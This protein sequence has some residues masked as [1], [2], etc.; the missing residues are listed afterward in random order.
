MAREPRARED[1]LMEDS[2]VGAP[3]RIG[4]FI[5][6]CGNN[7][8]GF[9]DVPQVTEYA[10]TLPHVVWAQD[11][12]YTCSD[13][14]RAEIV[15][16]IAEH[17]L[18]RVVVASCTPRTHEPLF[19]ATCEQ[20]GLNRYLFELVNIRDQCSWVHMQDRERATQKAKDLL[21]S[22]VARAALL[23]PQ[24]DIA[25]GVVPAALVIGAGIAGLNAALNLGNRGF[26]VY[27]V[28]RE[29]EMGGLLRGAHR[30]YPTGDDARGFVETR[31]RAVRSNPHIKVFTGAEVRD[32]KGFVGNY[33]VMV[34]QGDG[35]GSP[36]ELDLNV[37]T[38]VVATGA[39]VFR[40]DGMYGYDGKRVVTL[41]ELDRLLA[42]HM[43]SLS[44][45]V[46]SVVMIQ[47]VGSRNEERPYC[48]RICCMTAVRNAMWIMEANPGTQVYVLYRDMLTLGT[49]Y[50]D[51]YRE[52][53]GKGVIFIQYDPQALPVV[54]PSA[55]GGTQVVVL[56]KLLD[57]EISI[58]CDLVALSTPLIG[59][60][61]ATELAQMLKV[62]VDEHG[63][64]LEAH[65]KLRP[66]DFATDGIY[67]CGS[68]R[69]PSNVG[70]SIS[71]AQ[72][73]AGRA[74][75]LLSK[76]TVQVEPIVSVVDEEL[77][78]GC[79]LC[80]K[81]CP[82]NAIALYDTGTGRKA[83]TISASCKGCGVCG[84][85]CPALAISMQHFSNEQL[86]AQVD[87]LL[88]IPALSG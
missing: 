26:T 61:G 23:Q 1:E 48:S 62:P 25:V 24:E 71:Q 4:A 40:P 28:E 84:A 64:F 72:G 12:M 9:L 46:K 85:G 32:V 14:G 16:A 75:I 44:S 31:I 15:K 5:C 13:G 7:I 29:V 79:G 56:D 42:E 55:S 19:R 35:D 65:V 45:R 74:S 39:R 59:Q 76:G 49:V 22:G 38:I 36:R 69:F 82:Y 33:Q 34:E 57:Q 67:L 50:E 53:R 51:L 88:P 20:A 83:R 2:A 8:A 30:V 73:A 66:L 41:R 80:E 54:E 63:F 81:A 70:E 87:A 68:A 18:N 27:L 11:S 3:A 10:K 78:I 6:H 52:A 37:G 58:P 60:Q 86:F 21:R 17:N 43:G 77:C 47:C